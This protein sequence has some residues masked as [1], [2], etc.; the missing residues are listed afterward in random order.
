MVARLNATTTGH[1][2]PVPTLI[3]KLKINGTLTEEGL[4]G[5]LQ[6]QCAP[7]DVAQIS[8]RSLI[9]ATLDGEASDV[10]QDEEQQRQ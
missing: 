10:S 3:R 7:G 4:S 9:L 5:V 2:V 6:A 1:A 8:P